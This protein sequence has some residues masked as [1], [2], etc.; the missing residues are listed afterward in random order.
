MAM[1]SA[2]EAFN[3]KPPLIT[4]ETARNAE[5]QTFYNGDKCESLAGLYLHAI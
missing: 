4:K 2:K 1:V 5:L 3:G